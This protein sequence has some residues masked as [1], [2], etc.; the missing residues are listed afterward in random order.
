VAHQPFGPQSGC[1]WLTT[2]RLARRLND[3]DAR[4]GS[5]RA[6][7]QESLRA[8]GRWKIHLLALEAVVAA[9]RRRGARGRGVAHQARS[10]PG[11]RVRSSGS[12][13]TPVAGRDGLSSSTSLRSKPRAVSLVSGGRIGNSGR[14]ITIFARFPARGPQLFAHVLR[15]GPPVPAAAR[16]ATPSETAGSRKNRAD[17]LARAGATRL[18]SQRQRAGPRPAQA[19]RRG[20]PPAVVLPEPSTPLE[21]DEDAAGHQRDRYQLTSCG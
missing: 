10:R 1:R 12:G 11:N 8:P 7:G 19:R 5:A 14:E 20:S 13:R 18:V 17:C 6:D 15:R 21:R 9:P 3:R 4:P 2:A 16:R